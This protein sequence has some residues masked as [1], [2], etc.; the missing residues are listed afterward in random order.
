[1]QNGD[2]PNTS[3][4]PVLRTEAHW[5]LCL[6]GPSPWRVPAE[7]P[8]RVLPRT[9]LPHEGQNH[10]KGCWLVFIKECLV[11]LNLLPSLQCLLNEHTDPG[12]Q[13]SIPE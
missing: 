1:M 6:Q 9:T 11:S 8:G 2:N 3:C 12:L 5:S 13:E 4:F 10:R 7:M